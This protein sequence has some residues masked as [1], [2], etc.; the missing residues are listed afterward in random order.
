MPP[1][2]GGTMKTT[3]AAAAGATGTAGASPVGGG[4]AGDASAAAGRRVIRLRSRELGLEATTGAGE[5]V[6]SDDPGPARKK[7]KVQPATKGAKGKAARA[8]RP[9]PPPRPRLPPYPKSG[10]PMDVLK[11]DTE[12]RRIC[13]LPE[14]AGTVIPCTVRRKPTGPRTVSV[15]DIASVADN[16]MIRKASR[17]VVGISSRIPD[18]KEI[19][20]CS[21]I[22]VDWNKTSRLATIVTCSAAVCFDGALVHPNPKL[23]VH[24][25]NRSTA[26][27]QLL[28]FNAH[29]RIALLEALVDSPL[30]PANFGSSPKF[31]QKVFALA[32]DKKSSFF[33]RSGTVLLQDPPFFLKY[34]YWL[35]LS[36]AI[37][38]CGT[39]G[40]A[41][42]ERGDVA[43]M[44][45]GRLPNPDLLSIS[46]LQ[47]CI[48]MWRRFSRI[49][50]PFLRMDLIAFQTLDISH[51]EEIESEHG[52]TDGFIVDLVRHDSTAG[53]VGISRG[54]VIVSYNGLRDF[55]LHTFEEY[56]LNL[57]WGFLESTDPSWTINLELE[58]YDPVR[59]TIRGVTFPLGFSDIC[60]DVLVLP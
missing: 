42:D 25:P 57:G 24:L 40:P 19:M 3:A 56:L 9:T 47:T 32:R 33:A 23:L 52:I 53:R 50:R 46:I 58:I 48:D 1:K 59:R 34:K 45:F 49:A 12:F 6:A 29:Y 20:Q 60:E 35:S 11:W 51:Q 22:V 38:L 18:G 13:A 36:S 7:G 37:E 8:D 31:G 5:D 54:D 14:P 2:R 43:G 10:D 16:S 28:F 27:G 41:I 26:E 39:G 30:E 15:T 55:T 44:T 4:P 21:G 17:S